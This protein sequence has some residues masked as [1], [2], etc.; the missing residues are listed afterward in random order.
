MKAWARKYKYQLDR[1][2]VLLSLICSIG[3]IILVVLFRL[4]SERTLWILFVAYLLGM[5]ESLALGLHF[6]I[7]KKKVYW[8]FVLLGLSLVG[9][10]C[11]YFGG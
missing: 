6:Y 3:L 7:K 2:S 10:I 11:S 9:L 4:L 5:L 8:F 1:L